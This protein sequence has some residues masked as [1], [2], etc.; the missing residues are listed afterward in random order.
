MGISTTFE[1]GERLDPSDMIWLLAGAMMVAVGV[2]LWRAL[3]SGDDISLLPDGTHDVHVYKDQL[4]ALEHDQARGLLSAKEVE[5]VRLEL[6]RRLLAADRRIQTKTHTEIKGVSHFWRFGFLAF[7][8]V[9]A[10][11]LY[12]QLG[13]PD[14]PDQPLSVRAMR[15]DQAAA[16]ARMTHPL[17]EVD[18][19]HLDLIDQLRQAL[20]TRP[21]DLKGWRLLAKHEMQIGNPIAA[22]RAQERVVTLLGEAAGVEDYMD[23][24][25]FMIIAAGGYVSSD[26]EKILA[27]ALQMD[28]AAP[29]ARYY[30][31]LVLAQTGRPDMAYRVWVELLQ[32]GPPDAPWI[33]L[34][35]HQI[36][37]VAAVAGI[38]V[39]SHSVPGLSAEDIEAARALSPEDRAVMIQAMVGGLATR[40]ADEG[41][42]AAEWARLIRAYGVLGET[43]KAADAWD[44][45]KQFFAE[46]TNALAVLH[47]AARAAEVAQ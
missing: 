6:A 10:F 32:E 42:S 38:D 45:A 17:I 11:G 5:A 23:L 37:S 28:A 4:K 21:N 1:C 20:T 24:A 40:L 18:Q 39:P 12:A 34:I 19:A 15:L 14:L 3:S 22:W 16:E 43:A 9:G 2:L 30:S 31:G 7:V 27:K 36:N 35:R 13:R 26:V 47:D 33:P 25:E 41:G 44:K 46:D 8:C 29:R